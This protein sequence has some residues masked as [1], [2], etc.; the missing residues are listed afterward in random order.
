[1][2][3]SS[4][5]MFSIEKMAYGGKKATLAYMLSRPPKMVHTLSHREKHQIYIWRFS[6]LTPY[7]NRLLQIKLPP[8]F[9]STTP[10]PTPAAPPIATTSAALCDPRYHLRRSRPPLGGSSGPQS[11]T[12]APLVLSRW[13]NSDGPAPPVPICVASSHCRLSTWL[14]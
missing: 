10:A 13:P 4:S 7:C 1:M 6:L 9:G 12:S 5:I 11:V 3:S 14:S 2:P 8:P